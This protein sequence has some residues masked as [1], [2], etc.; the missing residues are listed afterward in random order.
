MTLDLAPLADVCIA[1]AA[2]AISA[3][4]PI[5][6][7]DLLRLLRIHVTAQQSALLVQA[8]SHGADLAV[9]EATLAAGGLTAVTIANAR[10]ATGAG[11][12]AA[13]VPGLL[14]QAGVT[15]EHVADLVRA[16]LASKAADL[17]GSQGSEAVAVVS[18]PAA[19]A[20]VAATRS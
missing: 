6:V 5:L 16:S 7:P 8:A 20:T 10:V 14:A 2:A 3:A 12:V 1:I 13:Y 4:I 9:H 15:P 19:P 11:Y 17:A 18:T